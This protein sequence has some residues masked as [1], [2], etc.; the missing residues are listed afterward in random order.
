MIGQFA[1]ELQT[2]QS[3][4]IIGVR[5]FS[6]ELY[7]KIGIFNQKNISNLL[8]SDHTFFDILSRIFFTTE[9]WRG[10]GA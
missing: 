10:A 6:A 2:V 4:V 5:I 1:F 7:E 8:P 3:K 9:V